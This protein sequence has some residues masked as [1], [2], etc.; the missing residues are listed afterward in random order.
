M[1]NYIIR[2]IIYSGL[3]IM[4][5]LLLTFV[6]FRLAAGDPA[7]AVLGKNPS[8]REVEDL[9]QELGADRPLVFG[10]WRQSEV[11]TSASF[12]EKRLMPG[13][14]VSGNPV[15]E[16]GFMRLDSGIIGLKRNFPSDKL[17]VQGKI[18]FRGEF[19]VNGRTF[20]AADWREIEFPVAASQEKVLI[21]AGK[22]P[23]EVK[24][25][26][27]YRRQAS[28][29]D[30]Q[31]AAALGEICS[32]RSEFPYVSF[33]NFG[34]TLMTREPI[35]EIL[36][37][38]VGPSM[39]LMLPIF[40][41]ELLLGIILALISTAFKGML[42][43]RM[44]V[45]FSIAGMSISYLVFIIFGQWY[46]GYYFNLFPVWGWGEFRHL[47]LPV[48]IGILSGLGGG[49]RFYRTVFVNE[50]NKEY[51]RT[52]AAKGCSP[53]VIYGRHLLRNASIPIITRASAA[54]PFLFTGS[55]LLE[56]F[57]GIP[58]LG[59]AGIDALNNSDLQLL[60]ALVLISAL[61]FVVINLMTDIA[62]AWADPRIRL[63][64]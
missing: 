16:N 7:A 20:N 49:V 55:L 39:A 38:G 31:L 19:A 24:E 21:A 42:F 50:L 61:L 15:F 47:A 13:M 33:F 48:I 35:R 54:L 22:V 36:W 10:Y 34:K 11:F 17:E 57:F 52:A 25:V 63:K 27:F 40:F 41:G 28:P 46:L 26:E 59:Y 5:V 53:A 30:S 43:D 64:S 60:K 4:G 45:L 9:R 18:V 23:L 51:L 32:F 44:I 8:P 56:A 37:R 14:E 29:L 2:R 58:G 62:Y 12:A 1:F 3:V 6:L